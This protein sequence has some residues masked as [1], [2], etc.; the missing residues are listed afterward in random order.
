MVGNHI[1]ISLIRP[2]GQDGKG[3]KR[4]GF[5]C[6]AYQLPHAWEQANRNR[7]RPFDQA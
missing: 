4:L 5:R 6:G 7:Q 3:L 2:G 1:D